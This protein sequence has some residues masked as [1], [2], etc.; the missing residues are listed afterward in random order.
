ML[1]C[2]I[3]FDSS[4]KKFWKNVYDFNMI[5]MF[6]RPKPDIP[7]VVEVDSDFIQTTFCKFKVCFTF[8]L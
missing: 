8:L 3:D 1:I 5:D 4:R 6:T 7:L 2:G